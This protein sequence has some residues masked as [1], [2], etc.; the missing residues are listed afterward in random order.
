MTTY[1]ATT[2][3]RASYFCAWSSFKKCAAPLTRYSLVDNTNV[4]T[5]LN[6]PHVGNRAAVD[7]ATFLPMQLNLRRQGSALA[8]DWAG[9]ALDYST[10]LVQWT[11]VTNAVQTWT[12]SVGGNLNIF[13]V[14][15]E[16]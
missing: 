3:P 12:P 9:G 4:A 2:L 7:W 11:A 14:R 10:N 13:R 5:L 16:R 1:L 6:A 15:R 8:V